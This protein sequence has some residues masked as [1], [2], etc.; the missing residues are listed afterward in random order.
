MNIPQLMGLSEDSLS[1]EVDGFLLKTPNPTSTEVVE[2]LKLYSAG[3]RR[4]SAARALIAKGV[5]SS[6][7]SN[8]LS[9]LDSSKSWSP[10]TFWGVMSLVSGAASAYHGYKRNNSVGWAV[11]WFFLG[12]ILPIFTPVIALA[13]GFGK[14]KGT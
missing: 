14:R 3:G 12:S 2:F 7:V 1:A 6:V 10:N 11:G 9:W 8:A 4:D 13:Q 5:S